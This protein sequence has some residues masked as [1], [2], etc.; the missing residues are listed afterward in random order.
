MENQR[1]GLVTAGRSTLMA[2]MALF[3]TQANAATTAYGPQERTTRCSPIDGTWFH[4]GKGIPVAAKGDQLLVNMSVFRRPNATGRIVSDSQIEVSFPDDATYTGTLDGQGQIS[5]S[6]GT[7]WQATQFAGK[8][9]FEGRPGPAVTQVGKR[10]KIGMESYGRPTAQG[11]ITG[12]STATVTFVDDA[13]HHAT[14][15]S[16]TCMQWSNGTVWTK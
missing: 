12:P 3:F 4:V 14:L 7:I 9:F 15:V 5:W 10:L 8:W 13:T 6:N 2:L 16:P 11:T 1:S